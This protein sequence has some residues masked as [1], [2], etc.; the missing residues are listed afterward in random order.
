MDA[1]FFQFTLLSDMPLET[2]S[3]PWYM[4]MGVLLLTISEVE[5]AALEFAS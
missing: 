3:V 1:I 2:H 4:Q 5:K